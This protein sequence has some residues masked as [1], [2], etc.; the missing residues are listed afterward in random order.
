MRGLIVVILLL[1]AA[2]CHSQEWTRFHYPRKN[3]ISLVP[4]GGVGGILA[5]R[6]L[7]SPT[8]YGWTAGGSLLYTRMLDDEVG[9]Q[10]GVGA[11]RVTGAFD[12]KDLT[13]GYL[14][15]V[16]ISDG[17]HSHDEA[18]RFVYVTKNAHESY[19][20]DLLEIPVRISY[21]VDNLYLAG[22]LK[23][24]FPLSMTADYDYSEGLIGISELVGTG[25]EFAEVVPT[26]SFPARD[27]SYGVCGLL[28]E[29]PALFVALSMEAGWRIPLGRAHNMMV[30]IFADYALNQSRVGCEG[31]EDFI[32]FEGDV[33]TY[34]TCMGSNVIEGFGYL[35]A[36]LR[37]TCQFGFGYEVGDD[38]VR[39]RQ[40]VSHT[41]WIERYIA[42]PVG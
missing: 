39:Y 10:I 34:R 13:S 12:G 37:L 8:S 30:G 7:L 3:N 4:D 21:T 22:G 28:D 15:S 38:H 27:G 14:S 23:L 11:R 16:S 32:S 36:G 42:K 2:T 1:S 17:G 5:N 40:Q 9:L 26:G 25:T 33:P 6:S 19:T 18:A 31:D 20:M 24:G 41:T 29:K 35:T